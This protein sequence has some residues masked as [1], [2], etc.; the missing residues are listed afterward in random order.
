MQVVDKDELEAAALEEVRK[1]KLVVTKVGKLGTTDVASRGSLSRARGRS[2]A[3]RLG[4]SSGLALGLLSSE[5][6]VL[7]VD[8]GVGE[9]RSDNGDTHLIAQ[10]LVHNGTEDDVGLGVDGVGGGKAYQ[11]RIW[12]GRC[13][14]AG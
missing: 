13:R 6:L 7:T 11:S 9:A 10:G 2:G 1:L 12:S 14:L 5:E 4:R 3:L 8:V